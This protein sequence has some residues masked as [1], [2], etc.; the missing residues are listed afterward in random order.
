MTISRYESM[1]DRKPSVLLALATYV[2]AA[3]LTSEIVGLGAWPLVLLAAFLAR[4]ASRMPLY[5]DEQ[6]HIDPSDDSPEARID[7]RLDTPLYSF[8]RKIGGGIGQGT[9]TLFVLLLVIG[10]LAQLPGAC[11]GRA[12]DQQ[13][14]YR[15]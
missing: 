12:P 15:P 6:S 2:G 3:W 11:S 8:L 7:R 10:M 13:V 4:G 1:T 5:R 9:G 14:E